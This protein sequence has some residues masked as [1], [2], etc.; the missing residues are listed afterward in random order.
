[1]YFHL[2]M[3]K[4]QAFVVKQVKQ[5]NESVKEL[6]GVGRADNDP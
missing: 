2:I 1:M 4:A 3:K 6:V 5:L